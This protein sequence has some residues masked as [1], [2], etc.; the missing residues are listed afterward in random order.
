MLND[1]FILMK[2]MNFKNDLYETL[3]A[4]HSLSK[5]NIVKYRSE[6]LQA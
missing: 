1:I 5:V 2:T 4:P 3:F 6:F